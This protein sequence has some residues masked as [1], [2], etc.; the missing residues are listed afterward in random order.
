MSGYVVCPACGTRMKAGR[1]HCLRCF[2]TLPV[3][4]PEAPQSWLTQGRTL[5]VGVVLTLGAL[6]LSAIIWERATPVVDDVARPAQ[7]APKTASQ[8]A[9]PSAEPSETSPASSG[10]PSIVE[11]GFVSAPRAATTPSADPAAARTAYEKTLVQRPDDAETLNKLGQTLVAL[12]RIDEAVPRF[13]RAAAVAPDKWLYQ[14]NLAHAA[15]Q[16]LLWDQAVAAYRRARAIQPSDQATQF[17]LALALHKKG[18]DAAAIPEFEKAITLAPSDA[19]AH[20]G[21]AIALERD[22]RMSDAIRSY[23]R[24]LELEPGSPDAEK[25]KL[26]LDSLSRA[27][28]ASNR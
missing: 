10:R 16:L 27:Q 14:F 21:L 26:Y 13:E 8:Q 17:D 1:G 20:L 4:A 6:L 5:I 23:R 2:E 25:L 19:R 18:D 28:P 22:G 15:S 24:F 9:L 7:S 12:G 11:P 3:D